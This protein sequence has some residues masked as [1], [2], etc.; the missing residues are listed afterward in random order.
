MSREQIV[1]VVVQTVLLVLHAERKN[2]KINSALTRMSR[3][4]R[5]VSQ[6]Q[7]AVNDGAGNPESSSGSSSDSSSGSSS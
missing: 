6:F 5:F 7:G 2:K 1:F 3:V 4:L